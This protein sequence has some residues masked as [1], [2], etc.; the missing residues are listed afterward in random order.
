MPAGFGELGTPTVSN[1]MEGVGES[2]GNGLQLGMNYALQ[3]QE[4]EMKKQQLQMLKEKAQGDKNEHL[5]GILEKVT[6]A[7]SPAVRKGLV[8]FFSRQYKMMNNGTDPSPDFLD[9]IKQD[10]DALNEVIRRAGLRDNTDPTQRAQSLA[11]IND[12]VGDPE[13]ALK[14]FD[15]L[16]SGPDKQKITETQVTGRKE[17]AQAQLGS[18]EAL[19]RNASAYNEFN[20]LS[21]EGALPVGFQDL[22]VARFQDLTPDVQ[23]R[24]LAAGRSILA[25]RKNSEAADKHDKI[26]SDIDFKEYRKGVIGQQLELAKSRLSLSQ[27]RFAEALNKDITKDKILLSTFED[28]QRAQRGLTLLNSGNVKWID[29]SESAA[30][31][32][33]LITGS[34]R[35]AQTQQDKI[36]FASAKRTWDTW[37]GKIQNKEMGGPSQGEI[38]LFR[39]RLQRLGDKIAIAHDNRLQQLTSSQ[40]VSGLKGDAYLG[41]MFNTLKQNSNSQYNPN[42]TGQKR[43][44]SVKDGMT[45]SAKDSSGVAVSGGALTVQQIA[46]ER[47]MAMDAIKAGAD[48]EMVRKAFKKRTGRSHW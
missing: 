30:D 4:M 36:D 3:Q 12:A 46:A 43:S 48:P 29:L 23:A 47:K 2:V 44:G 14:F 27:Q 17:V 5:Y 8:N 32:N 33:R 41:D 35:V 22:D 45:G 21:K 11:E 7:K 15:G 37:Q 18:R 26:R 19:A 28:V 38:A 42:Y 6:A 39:G 10:P 40:K 9:I 16:T 31:I 13:Q 34:S 20:N 1:P 24:V 25:S